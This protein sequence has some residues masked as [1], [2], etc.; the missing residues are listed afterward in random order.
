MMENCKHDL[1]NRIHIAM[2][3]FVY[4]AERYIRV[5]GSTVSLTVR[6]MICSIVRHSITVVDFKEVNKTMF[7]LSREFLFRF[8]IDVLQNN[9]TRF[10]NRVNCQIVLQ[11]AMNMFIGL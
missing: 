3:A 2:V 5:F 7:E 8:S 4:N 9:R 1:Q 6:H 10:N 11:I